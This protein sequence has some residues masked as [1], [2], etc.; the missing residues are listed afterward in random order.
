M[1]TVCLRR[2]CLWLMLSAAFAAVAQ[3]YVPL[4][5]LPTAELL[6]KAEAAR[7]ATGR[8]DNDTTLICYSIASSRYA[9]EL[10][11]AEK[12]AV[13]RATMELYYIQRQQFDDMARGLSLLRK[14]NTI[15]QDL[16]VGQA[17]ILLN[18]GATYQIMANTTQRGD[19]NHLALSTYAQGL[20]EALEGKGSAVADTLMLC[21]INVASQ[22]DRLDSVQPMV[23]R[24]AAVPQ[25]RDTSLLRRYNLMLNDI[26]TLSARKQYPQAL[27]KCRQGAGMLEKE[28]AWRYLAYSL[29]NE[30]YILLAHGK[31][32]QA[33]ERLRESEKIV[34]AHSLADF[35]NILY[36]KTADIARRAGLKDVAA[37]YDARL[38]DLRAND[39]RHH[40]LL[41]AVDMENTLREEHYNALMADNR[42]REARQRVIILALIVVALLTGAFLLVVVNR[43]RRLRR[44]HRRIYQ[45]MQAS[46]AAGTPLPMPA[47]AEAIPAAEKPA[48]LAP[49][50]HEE[51]KEA[52]QADCELMERVNEVLKSSAEI[53]NSDFGIESLASLMGTKSRPLSAAINRCEGCSFSALLARRRIEEACRR[54][55]DRESYGHL[56]IEAIAAGVGFK[57]RSHFTLLFKR[58]AGMRPSEYYALAREN[59]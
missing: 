41:N 47:Q 19:Y 5:S 48:E 8:P 31:P 21:V 59:V 30:A 54:M 52:T 37:D 23:R 51:H 33:M 36:E 3:D 9:P 6:H 14:A 58:Y 27:A 57:S 29:V 44:A 43:N 16:G 45:Q 11:R 18:L 50:G 26:F 20:N 40:Q 32:A 10:S 7:R 53:Y 24:Y 22:I 49:P 46:L 38:S 25:G 17:P 28:G 39:K 56:T 1:L 34:D 42:V 13:A 2:F 55:S 12:L 35:R 4:Y 15:Y